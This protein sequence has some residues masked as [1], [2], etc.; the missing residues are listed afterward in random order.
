[1]K[2]DKK[3]LTFEEWARIGIDNGYS[4][5][6]PGREEIDEQ[7][8]AM[9]ENA[10]LMDGF[11]GAI[12]GFSRRIN[13][14]L[15]V[16]YSWQKMMDTLITRDGMEY[17]EAEEYIEYNCIGAWVGERTPIIVGPFSGI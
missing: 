2:K 1:M 11:D 8:K 13:E 7:L 10:L 17:E 6:S 4:S 15:L 12:I 16:V 14:P 5:G 3:K 9:E